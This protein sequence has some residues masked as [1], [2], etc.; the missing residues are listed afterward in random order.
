MINGKRI[1]GIFM[2]GILSIGLLSG[3]GGKGDEAAKKDKLDAKGRYVEKEI[4]LPQDGGKLIGMSQIDNQPCL[5]VIKTGESSSDIS[6]GSYAWDGS[7]WSDRKEVEWLNDGAKRLGIGS[8]QVRAGQDGNLYAFGFPI[9]E[10]DQA[11][12]SIILKS[13]EDGKTAED[14]TPEDLKKVDESGYASLIVDLDVL[15]DGSLAIVSMMDQPKVYK[16]GKEV[17]SAE[18]I[19]VHSNNQNVLTASGNTFAVAGSDSKTIHIYDGASFE[20]KGSTTFEQTLYE[21]Q[22]TKG[23]KDQWYIINAKGIHRFQEN[24]SIV[25]TLMEGAGGLMAMSNI[26]PIAFERGDQEDFYALYSDGSG[27]YKMK[28][29]VFDSEIA[30]VP[31]KVLTVYGLKESPTVAQA[32]YEFQQANPDVKVE[33]TTALAG[34]DEVTADAVKSLN[35]ELVSGNGAD[36]LIL[37]G[38]PLESYI[39]KG[40]LADMTKFSKTL[41]ENEV[42]MDV[43]GSAAEKDGEIY[44]LP[45]KIGVPVYYGTEE[46]NQ[47]LESLEALHSY[48]ENH[49]D[50]LLFGK[51]SHGNVGMALLN[52]M[53]SELVNEDGSMDETRLTRFLEDWMKLCNTAETKK[54]EEE[55]QINNYTGNEPGRN[56]NS[57]PYIPKAESTHI[58][59]LIGLDSM[60][61]PFAEMEKFGQ[62]LSSL[63]G[64]Y[65]PYVIAGINASSDQQELAQEFIKT[66][67]SD[68]VQGAK[69]SDGYP[70]TENGLASIEAYVETEAA[71]QFMMSSST[72]D[73]E[74]GEITEI[75]ASYPDG[76]K[77]KVFN[78]I[79]RGLKTPFL[80]DRVMSQTI[81]EE[82]DNLYNG[83]VDA[84]G[85]AKAIIQ[86]MNT[87]LAE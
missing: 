82:M 46:E 53:Y 9:Q 45:A 50:K 17:F 67:F 52:T 85:A 15:S 43:I 21:M 57:G 30:A 31:D 41:K 39:E 79:V 49:P 10:Q 59:E 12:G 1:I 14:I 42:L 77:I 20:E 6:Y 40:I 3:C 55:F 13:S 38:L 83:A 64:L 75:S 71:A 16:D 58:V 72:T 78:E 69:T 86:K 8:T 25:E 70:V 18:G 54:F 23:D 63:K 28:Y 5:Y 32:I 22:L 68:E 4:E 87:Y 73:P 56:F 7:K 19:E 76:E 2:A 27:D 47:A 80:T 51:I 29:Y 34:E 44:A 11:Y 33:Y 84:G 74:T 66:L 35:T 81:S 37:D 60:L 62:T 65:V 36:V 48:V 61:M 24:G 26:T